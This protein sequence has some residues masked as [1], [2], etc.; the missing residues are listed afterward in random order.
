[1]CSSHVNATPYPNRSFCDGRVTA[2]AGLGLTLPRRLRDRLI[3]TRLQA[4]GG[5]RQ[6]LGASLW[7]GQTGWLTLRSSNALEDSVNWCF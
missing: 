2:I 7:D 1:M 4:I 6:A 5:E 3:D